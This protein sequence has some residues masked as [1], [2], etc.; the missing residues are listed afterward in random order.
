M[1]EPKEL[2][3][4]KFETS[5]E[6]ELGSVRRAYQ[7]IC[8]ALGV[9]SATADVISELMERIVREALGRANPNRVM[10][11]LEQFSELWCPMPDALRRTPKG[12]RGKLARLTTREFRMKS[13]RGRK[14]PGHD[15]PAHEGWEKRW[16]EKDGELWLVEMHVSGPQPISNADTAVPLDEWRRFKAGQKVHKG[17][18]PSP[19]ID[20]SRVRFIR[21]L[22]PASV[23]LKEFES[24]YP[25]L[26]DRHDR[27][28]SQLRK[29]VFPDVPET[30]FDKWLSRTPA[31]VPSEIALLVAAHRAKLTASPGNLSR[32]R[33]LVAGARLKKSHARHERITAAAKKQHQTKVKKK[34]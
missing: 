30:T 10:S 15:A 5:E 19:Q 32:L 31:L 11:H 21:P 9:P 14:N 4:P 23:L 25:K 2:P 27:R 34:L 29:E 24:L 1:A 18:L 26:E 33:E 22:D 6:A 28:P 12:D 13:A 16:V 3:I 8:E 20:L 17:S 7:D